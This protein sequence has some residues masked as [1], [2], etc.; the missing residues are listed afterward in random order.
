MAYIFRILFFCVSDD[1]HNFFY[2]LVFMRNNIHKINLDRAKCLISPHHA[3][4]KFSTY[5]FTTYKHTYFPNNK[6]LVKI[7]IFSKQN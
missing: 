7:I 3:M 6:I 5:K 1:Q 2:E 4:T